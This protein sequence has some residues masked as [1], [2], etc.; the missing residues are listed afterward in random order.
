M[1]GV[2]DEDIWDRAKAAA[3]K[4]YDTGSDIYWPVVSSVYQKMGGTFHGKGEAAEA[5]SG[6]S[7]PQ[8]LRQ[9]TIEGGSGS[10]GIKKAAAPKAPKAPK[11][12]SPAMA[13]KVKAP[14]APKASKQPK[15]KPVKPATAKIPSTKPV[16]PTVAKS[17][18]AKPQKPTVLKHSMRNVFKAIEGIKKRA[19]K[20]PSG[21]SGFRILETRFREA[22]DTSKGN[23]FKA[24]LIQEGMGNF[25]DKFYYTAEAI[26]SA[27]SLFE[28]KKIYADHP[29]SIEEQVIPERS[30]R[31]VLGHFEN[32]QV[33]EEDDGHHVLEAD[34]VILPEPEFDWA[35]GLM[36]HAVDYSKKYPD[37]DFVGLSIN[38]NGE[39]DNKGLEDFIQENKIPAYC[40]DKL[41]EA[42]DQG[43]D[44]VRVVN[45]LTAAVS[46]DLVTE[47]GAGGRVTKLIEGDRMAKK[48]LKEDGGAN[49]AAKDPKSVPASKS[50]EAED[51][52]PDKDAKD[53]DDG[54]HDD[55]AKDA[56][57]IKSMLKK[58]A[59]DDEHDEAAHSMCA[60]AYEMA[61][62]MGMEGDE[63]EKHAVVGMKMMKALAKKAEAAESEGESESESETESETEEADDAGKSKDKDVP[64]GIPANK[65]SGRSKKLETENLQL[66]GTVAKLEEKNRKFEISAHLEAKLEKSG[67]SRK[68]TTMFREAIDLGAI[69]STKEIDAKW[70]T[71]I[72]GYRLGRDAVGMGDIVLNVEKRVVSE[73][74]GKSALDLTDCA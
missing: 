66:R 23:R 9:K 65:E 70:D 47:A 21:V 30:V 17:P 1:P 71:Y 54:D 58:H 28:G 51:A 68:V 12:P 24:V 13:A 40:L 34:V 69:K 14:K 74:G 48:K 22:A 8:A 46:C 50:Y 57:L 56:E 72:Q 5:D 3:A 61:K 64:A 67:E 73:D 44:S 15:V 45:K 63:A 38:A 29:T 20:L 59:P 53:G 49:L 19:V 11:P 25:T 43:I 7:F 36:K 10:G 39:A 6:S 55:A 60:E 18:S 42:L 26:E 2:V 27:V 52:P 41:K 16:K 4:T 37:K 31:D 33:V 32:C 35:R 62:D